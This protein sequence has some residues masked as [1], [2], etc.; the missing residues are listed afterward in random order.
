MSSRW[1]NVIWTLSHPDELVPGRISSGLLTSPSAFPYTSSMVR[2]ATFCDVTLQIIYLQRLLRKTG[3]FICPAIVASVT[4][5]VMLVE[6][7]L[8][9]LM[10]VGVFAPAKLHPWAPGTSSLIV[11]GEKNSGGVIAVCYFLRSYTRF[12]KYLLDPYPVHI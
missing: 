1:H 6:M 3:S 12:A 10:V 8:V 4:I 7:Q 5:T 2:C 11:T 9:K